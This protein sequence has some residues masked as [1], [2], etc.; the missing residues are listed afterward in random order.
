MVTFL[1]GTGLWAKLPAG[2]PLGNDVEEFGRGDD[3]E[4]ARC[5]IRAAAQYRAIAPAGSQNYVLAIRRPGDPIDSD[6]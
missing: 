4:E 6:I 5:A 1:G 2:L 3:R